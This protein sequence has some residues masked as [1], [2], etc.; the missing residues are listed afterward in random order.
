MVDKKILTGTSILVGTCIGAGILGIPFVAAKAGFFTALI[1]IIAVG[2]ITYLINMYLGEVSLRTKQKHQIVG[3]AEKYLGKRG[4]RLMEFATVFGIYAAI[5][6][7]MVGVGESLSFL[8]FENTNY[9]IIF[10][11]FFGIIMSWLLWSGKKALKRYEKLGVG[12]IML[13]LAFIIIFFIPNVE[14]NNLIG[15]DSAN[16]FLPFGV[17]LFALMSFHAVPEINIVLGKDKKKMKKIILLSAII[18]VVIYTLFTLIVVGFMGQSTPEVATLALGK[19]F[20]VLG[21]FTMFTSYLSLGTS[22]E[23]DFIFDEHYKKKKSWILSS[24]LPIIVFILLQI[25]DIFSFTKILAIG[26][27]VSGGLASILILEMNKHAKMKKERKP[28]YSVRINNFIIILLSL[29]FITG[30][31][32]QLF[33]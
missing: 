28:E 21:I 32:T 4:K 9:S 3:Y 6:A 31:I 19:V 7:Y 29:I 30:V 20:V 33:F 13:L 25:F 10:G 15:F 11:I 5:I 1:Y 27:V 26:G 23:D 8:F 14:F 24:M 22:L 2:L 17:I 18:S 12:I 16:I